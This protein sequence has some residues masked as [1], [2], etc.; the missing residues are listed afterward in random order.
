MKISI[1]EIDL[2]KAVKEIKDKNYKLIGI[3]VPEGLKIHLFKI[4]EILKKETDAE[5]VICGD[6]CYGACDLVDKKYKGLGVE[7]LIHIGHTKIPSLKN[8]E[9][10]VLFL[11]AIADLDIKEVLEKAIP[12]INGKN[13]G[14]L[15]TAQ[16]SHIIDDVIKILKKNNFNPVVSDGDKRIDFPGQ[17]L[18]CNFSSASRVKDKVDMYLFIGSG[19]FHP[20]GMILSTDKDVIV[21]DPYS[22]KVSF[23]ELSEYKDMLLKQ[24]YGAIS[25]SKMA[26]K[27]GIIISHKEGQKRI[28]EAFKLKDMI[29]KKGRQAFVIA[30]DYLN[31]QSLETFRE[32]DCFVSTAC[33]RIAID[34]YLCY[35]TP[36][37]TPVELEIVLGYRKWDEYK[38]DEILD[39]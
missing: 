8:T 2:E 1:Y 25:N 6:P 15:T 32:I 24:R 27:F 29:E 22:K 34:D 31:P 3:Q 16:H 28:D 9:I 39:K 17:I 12:S 19:N 36:I 4:I 23:R 13:I 7:L 11:N 30:V 18:G 35:K 21:C 26:K 14:I 37:I 20:L 10:P 33:P 5:Y 38:F